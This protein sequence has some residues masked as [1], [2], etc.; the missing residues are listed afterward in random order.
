M[1]RTLST[2]FVLFGMLTAGSLSAVLEADATNRADTVRE[3]S[4]GKKESVAQPGKMPACDLVHNR[5]VINPSKIGGVKRILILT[6]W[7]KYAKL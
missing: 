3:Q 4:V 5:A 7:R 1:S 6:C 2:S